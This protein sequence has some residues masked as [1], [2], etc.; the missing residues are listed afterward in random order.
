MSG[1]QQLLLGGSQAAA[2]DPFFYSVT[3]LLHGD[4]TNGAQ[5][6]TFLDSSTN[7][8]TIT[9][10]G[11]TTQGSFSPFSQ[12]GWG[13]YFN[14]SSYISA[15]D[16]AALDLGTGDF[17]I[18]G[19]VYIAD[20]IAD[21][22]GI[23]S[24]RSASTFNAGDYR[25]SYRT[26]TSKI[27]FANDTVNERNTPVVQKNSWTHFAI[28]R[29]SGTLSAYA[30]GVRG[31]TVADS[32]NLTNGEIQTIGVNAS[33]FFTGYMSN[34][35]IVKGTAVYS[36]ATYIVPTAP[37]T[38][39][40]GTSLLT[41]QSNRFVD[42][43]TNAFAISTSGSPSVQPFS[44][45][46]PTTAYS[47]SAV[48]GSGYF[49]GS[50]DY[51]QNTSVTNQFDVG[52]A[53]TLE[54]WVYVTTYQEAGWINT[55]GST[56]NWSTSTGLYWS[57][58]QFSGTLYWQTGNG[59]GSAISMITATSP[60]AG[61][62]HHVAIGYNG[63]T[64]RMWIDGASVGTST[65]SYFKPSGVDRFQI[66]G[67]TG[68]S[69]VFQ[70]YFSGL[71]FVKG[72]DVY[73]VGNTTLTVPTAPP[74][75]ISGTSLLCNFT[76]AG[77]F[78]NAAD[79][80]YETVGNA[81]ISTSV[82]KYGTGSMAFDGTGD[83]L[84][85]N[86]TPNLMA[87]GT[88]NFTLE[89]WA[90]ATSLPASTVIFIDYRPSGTEG[91]Y[92]TIYFDSGVIKYFTN[93]ADRITGIALSVNTWYHIALCR[94]AG[95]TRLFVNGTQVGST[96]ADTNNYLAGSQRPAIG[97]WGKTLGSNSY[98]GY[99]DDYRISLGVGRYPYNF[100][101]P[102]AEFP[103][104]GGT[105]TLTA[106][107]YYD[108]T[109][110]LLP[111]NGTNGAQNNTFLDSST[112]A[113]SITRNG[114]TTQ[115]TFS[116]FS[117]TGWGNYFDGSGDYCTLSSNASMDFGTGNFTIECWVFTGVFSVSAG[118]SRTIIGNSGNS[119]T[120]QLYIDTT[121]GSVVFGNTGSTFLQGTSTVAD[122]QWHHVVVVRSGTGSNQIA[123][124]VDGNRQ[125]LG[126]NSQNYT[127][128]TIY[129]GSFD[130]ANGFWNGYISN[131]RI[132]KGTA[133]Y[134]PTV[135]T[136]TVPTAPLTAITNTALLTFQSNR[137]LDNSTNAYT[138]TRNGDVSVQ[139]FSPFNP[140]AAWSAA[141]YGG[142][143]Y[144]DGSGDYLTLADNAALQMGSGNFTIEYWWY[145]TSIASYQNPIDK[146]YTGSGALLLQTGN[147]DGIIIVYASGSAVITANTAVRANAWNHMALVRNG[148]SLVLY[149]NGVSVGSATNSTN[150]NSTAAL[151]IG[152]TATAPGGGGVGSFPIV[153]Y[154]ND[155][156]F[157]KGTAVYTAAFTPPTA[158]LTAI[159]NT[160]LL[161]SFT[162]AG[163]YDATSKNDLE[164]VGNAQISTA[165]SKFGGS[166]MLFDGSGDYLV[167]PPNVDTDF[168]SGD[169]TAEAW[170]YPSSLAA[171]QDIFGKHA[172]SP[173][174]NS[175][176]GLFIYVGA[177]NSSNEAGIVSGNT[178]YNVTGWSLT[179]GTWQ[180][181]AFTRYAG[182]L[183]FFING[184][185]VGATVSANVSIN[186]NSAWRTWIGT[187]T[188]A[189]RNWNGY[190]Q[191]VRFTKG[192]ARYTSNFT[193][194]TTAF[195]TL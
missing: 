45:F 115:G 124:F 143:G 76:N 152:A 128:G 25:I 179:A 83:Y 94:V 26:G 181:I 53:F 35:R 34:I 187:Y 98:T 82:K 192:I 118:A 31:D 65:S 55:G 121:S 138:I 105:V 28:V 175:T 11:N 4:G 107:P 36:G 147:G 145:P 106:D 160:S 186:S 69:P 103:N 146:G 116:P 70:G 153:G 22:A 114:N 191:D 102:T 8:F 135:A 120:M 134:D 12:T 174:G 63:T 87:F 54:L 61:A 79:A 104:I 66:G 133:V 110:L 194:P 77:I 3:S 188:A 57:L 68:G 184:V 17:T 85:T 156:R 74:T 91:L 158:P 117:Q 151:G 71:R 49:D 154:L 168:G 150:F 169:F 122:N 37:L 2:V 9:R 136:L 170:V 123:L 90:Y 30:N 95:Q 159:A 96:Y 149:L 40:S 139:A 59:S 39:I 112:N 142:S 195:L 86:T 42:N 126:T 140:T 52:S 67:F 89:C 48:G 47:T 189:L 161:T 173:V 72:T 171:A 162:N 78:D 56:V 93:S 113:F 38:A 50:G 99:I 23:V 108:Y 165:Q 111:G 180:H 92:P 127:S 148:T 131:L 190:L 33:I 20:G 101:P 44:P 27:S 167:A 129:L 137:F 73:G 109:T 7:N 62:W 15:A 32:V 100:T 16:N 88:G 5:N 155:V 177:N 75:A 141:T 58:Y 81:Q 176:V 21:N 6:N 24:K 183:R 164:T 10:N 60:S 19:W 172:D 182:S 157:V 14:G 97:T 130:T 51:L 193:P 41:C 166:S 163:I 1:S 125:T 80:D 46:N 185:Q 13:N 119:Y 84:L 29:A 132:V 178:V 144:F 64:T 18:E 43:S